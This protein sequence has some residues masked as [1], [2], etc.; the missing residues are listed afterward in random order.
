MKGNLDEALM[1]Y[2]KSWKSQKIWVQFHHLCFWEMLWVNCMKTDWRE[3][4]LYASYLVENSIWSRTIYSYQKASL[5]CMLD[6]KDLTASE[7]RTIDQLLR[8]VPIH[9]QR[10]AG[11]SLPMEKFAI[12]RANRYFATGIL[13][14]PAIE[15]MFLWNLF[16]ISGKF[17]QIADNLYKIIERTLNY[18]ETSESND[19]IRKYEY[20]NR[21]L[22]L[23]L[24]VL[25]TLRIQNFDL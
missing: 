9:K 16:K 2:K 19:P 6:P 21:A 4:I 5:M 7:K 20:D 14:I 13:V 22:L 12:K 23:L 11:K 3:S 24:K 8:E 1:W 25:V 10:I 17:F 15:L 18:L